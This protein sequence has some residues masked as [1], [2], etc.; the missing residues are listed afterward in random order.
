MNFKIRAGE[1][2]N[3]A[4]LEKS[5]KIGQSTRMEV[6]TLL[7]KPYGKGRAMLPFHSQPTAMWTYYYEESDP[8]DSRRVMLFIYFDTDLYDGYMWFSGFPE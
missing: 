3:T 7:G 8:Q 1:M 4:A 2:P 6:E 5:L